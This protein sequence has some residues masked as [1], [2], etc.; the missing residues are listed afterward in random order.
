MPDIIDVT[1]RLNYEV[2]NSQL[3]AAN[4]LLEQQLRLTRELQSKGQK[5]ANEENAKATLAEA[6]ARD[7]N[8]N[9]ALKEAKALT[10]VAKA[11]KLNAQEKAILTKIQDNL[12]K[13]I[14][15]ANAGKLR[16]QKQLNELTN[17]YKQLSLA[18]NEAKAKAQEYSIALGAN[19]PVA[20]QYQQDAQKIYQT[21]L[22]V[23]QAVGDSRRQVGNYNVV[24]QQLTRTYNGLGFAFSQLLR[25]A[26]AFTY[27]I[28]TGILALSNNIPIL[29]DQLALA[30]KSGESFVGILKALAGAIF[31]LTGII[32]IGVAALTIFGGELFKT[33]KA[34]KE[35]KKSTEELTQA[36]IEQNKALQESLRLYRNRRNEGISAAQRE[37]NELVALKAGQD[38]IEAARKKLTDLKKNDLQDE[39]DRYDIIIGKTRELF[40]QY[41]T[42]TYGGRTFAATEIEQRKN[43]RE[44]LRPILQET[45]NITENQAQAEA[46]AIA[47]TYN[48]RN[49]AIKK[50]IDEKG[51]L[52]EQQ[53]DLTSEFIVDTAK[54]NKP[55]HYFRPRVIGKDEY[56]QSIEEI[57]E[58]TRKL[59]ESPMDF[60]RRAVREAPR[61][62]QGEVPLVDTSKALAGYNDAER[63]RKLNEDKQKKAIQELK[64][65]YIDL[66]QTIVEAFAQIQEAQ[67]RQL[68]YEL[69]V[70]QVRLQQANIL[71]ERGLTDAADAEMKQINRVQAERER[72]ARQQLQI[73]AVL[74][75][76]NAAVTLTEAIGAVV[77]AAAQ[78]DPYTIAA[79]VAAAVAALVAGVA[80]VSTAVSSANAP[81]GFKDG[82][83]A[84]QGAGTTTSD[85]IPARLSKGESV[86][87]AKSTAKN[88]EVL[89]MIN[90]GYD[91]QS[92]IPRFAVA[93]MASGGGKQKESKEMLSELRQ[94][95]KKKTTL[96]V[97]F[98]RDGVRALVTEEMVR[99]SYRF[100]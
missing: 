11:A 58:E 35:V 87:N 44:A 97:N 12:T 69:S 26:P 75:A 17:D 39:I 41:A 73:N 56:I 10:E 22:Q 7:I 32:T 53:R 62:R 100:R 92:M 88:K 45:L 63:L 52:V 83:I 29:L 15:K 19:H 37:L 46:A 79:R 78:G 82:V 90:K 27:S 31:S 74:Q 96:G 89:E 77:K 98:D 66:A 3:S 38:K 99:D 59:F 93:Q 95:N 54:A 34:N 57:E 14:D 81:K 25:E 72:L 84:I 20:Q 2:N 40:D 55:E 21:L 18:Y 67:I 94:L 8:A 24:A 61:R 13:S 48:T 1:T 33:D 51:K 85:S 71:A 49:S 68:D 47:N 80:A 60:F 9:A 6:R 43:V 65:A 50:Y 91:V 36:I 4:Q 23:D 30:R 16:E 42:V 86:I 64:D 28:Q 5:A 70:R 76:S